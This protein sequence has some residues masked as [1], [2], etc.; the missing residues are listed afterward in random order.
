MS[1]PRPQV[2]WRQSDDAAGACA[3]HRI[4][5]ERAPPGMVRR[6]GMDHFSAYTGR[7]GVTLACYDND[8]M[9]AYGQLGLRS[10]VVGELAAKLGADPDRLC[11][12]D[13]AAALPSWRGFGMHHAS[14]E[15]RLAYAAAS[16]R[17]LV[18]ATV[19]PGNLRALR[20]LLRAGLQIRAFAPMY[21]GL[22]RL[23]VQRDLRLPPAIPEPVLEVPSGDE[24]AHRAALADQLAGYAC[25]QQADGSWSVLYGYAPSSS[26]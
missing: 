10:A 13:G 11:V 20:S 8:T 2:I 16:D 7:D 21:G 1:L 24:H 19:S 5:F 22:P 14:I 23:I 17:P 12:L 3:I 26:V 18:A 4:A 25:R 6:D 15:Q 9:V